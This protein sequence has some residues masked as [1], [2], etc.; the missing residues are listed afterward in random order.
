MMNYDFPTGNETV[1]FLL[2]G[3][4]Y[5]KTIRPGVSAYAEVTWDLINDSDSPYEA[6]QPM[7]SLGVAAGF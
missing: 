6:G 7:V 2:V 4:G 3:G 1:P 5:S